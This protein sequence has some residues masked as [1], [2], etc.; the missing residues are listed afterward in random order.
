[1]VQLKGAGASTNGWLA[2]WAMPVAQGAARTCSGWRVVWL[3]LG[4]P[5]VNHVMWMEPKNDGDFAF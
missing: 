1:M 3:L 5:G 2:D 4:G